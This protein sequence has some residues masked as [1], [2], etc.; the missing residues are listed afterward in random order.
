MTISNL[1]P[2]WL[3]PLLD[4]LQSPVSPHS[5]HSVHHSRMNLHRIWLY[6]HNPIR[7]LKWFYASY[8]IKFKWF[9]QAL[10]LP[11][12]VHNLYDPQ[13]AHIVLYS[14]QAN[15]CIMLIVI[16]GYQKAK[17]VN[18]GAN[19]HAVGAPRPVRFYKKMK[20]Y[21]RVIFF[22]LFR[23]LAVSVHN[24]DCDFCW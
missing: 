8:R 16:D 3:K 24:I 13:R 4:I 1:S 2:E 20:S 5:I 9:T 21:Y 15:I 14:T 10:G 7:K 6:H 22:I 19:I 11:S 23:Y 17:S 18:I 12:P